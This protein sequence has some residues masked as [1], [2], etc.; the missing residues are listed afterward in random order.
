MTQAGHTITLLHGGEAYFAALVQAI[1]AA[2][3]SVGLETYI[4]DFNE[5]HGLSSIAVARAL[6]HAAESGVQV[7]LLMDG[8]GTGEVPEAW[9]AEFNRAGVAWRVYSPFGLTAYLQPSRWRRLHRKLCA[10]DAQTES[11]IGFCGGINLLDDYYDPNHGALDKPRFDFAIRITG[12]L[13]QQIADAQEQ[14]WSWG[15]A[16]R[17]ARQAQVRP[18]LT[19]LR[20]GS[21]RVLS[22]IRPERKASTEPQQM[23]QSAGVRAAL[24]LRDNLLNRRQIERAYRRAIGQAEHEVWIANAYFVPGSKF[25]RALIEAAKRGVKVTLLLQGKREYFF[26]VHATRAIYAPLLQAGIRIVE[27]QAS[28]LHAKVAVIDA[29][30][31]QTAWA[32]VGS[33]NL[34]P[35]SLL[36]AR[37]ANVVVRDTSFATELRNQ[38]QTACETEGV[39]VQA[40]AFLN[41]PWYDRLIDHF[42]YRFMRLSLWLLG[43]RY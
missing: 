9:Q 30:D 13:I 18:I 6:V 33:S 28:F 17:Q 40:H 4:F 3:H 2:Q 1:N 15:D 32:T 27:Y 11:A 14:L 7:R 43:K 22:A 10:V 36:M 29:D 24:L 38:L 21:A 26:Q 12:P 34:D 31:A 20:T 5:D 39:D 8:V 42:A 19:A 41:R 35:F 23:T 25:R 37:E 16:A